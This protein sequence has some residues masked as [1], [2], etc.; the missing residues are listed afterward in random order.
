MV[1]KHGNTQACWLRTHF[2]KCRGTRDRELEDS[3]AMQ[4]QN[5][6]RK[7]L[8]LTRL[9]YLTFPRQHHKAGDR[10]FR[11]PRR[12]GRSSFKAPDI[13]LTVKNRERTNIIYCLLAAQLAS[14]NSY[15]AWS[16]AQ[17]TVSPTFKVSL[18]LSIINQ[19]S[20]QELPALAEVL[21]SIPSSHRAA[22]N[23][24]VT[25]VPGI[26]WPFHRH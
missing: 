6:H 7:V 14:S 8:L 26:W 23:S 2:L 19:E 15:I 11:Y 25:P 9:H 18:S 17:K 5:L 22:H 24:S 3:W 4:L 13:A 1:G 12:Q 16:P 10:V 20:S 21:G